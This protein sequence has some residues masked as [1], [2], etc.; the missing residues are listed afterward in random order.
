MVRTVRILSILFLLCVGLASPTLRGEDMASQTDP[1]AGTGGLFA[2]YRLMLKDSAPVVCFLNAQNPDEIREMMK[3]PDGLKKI[4]QLKERIEELSG[5]PCRLV[6]Y[7]QI[8]RKDF[9]NPN[10]KAIVMTAWKKLTDPK[11]AEELNAL[12]RETQVPFI[13]F[14]GGCSVTYQAFGGKGAPMRRLRPGEPDPYPAYMPGI[15]KEWGWGTVRVVKRDPLF[16]GLKDEFI[17]AQRHYA[18]NTVLPPVFDVLAGSDECKV[19]VIK[20]KERP[21]YGTQFHP[22]MY[23]DEHPDGKTLI[24]N[25]FRIAGIKT[26]R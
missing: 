11:Q 10:I 22:E 15:F 3:K 6:N 25:F 1:L 26:A 17:V 4:I 13:A 16:D 2:G 19:Q 5:L 24:R 21:L 14:C 12:I 9:A 20:H 7:A 18:E 8:S 23:D